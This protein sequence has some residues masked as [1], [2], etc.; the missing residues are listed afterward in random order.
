MQTPP[1]SSNRQENDDAVTAFD[2]VQHIRIGIMS[3]D[4]RLQQLS[5]ALQTRDSSPTRSTAIFKGVSTCLECFQAFEDAVEDLEG[6]S[7]VQ[8]SVSDSPVPETPPPKPV[9]ESPDVS[10][11]DWDR[12]LEEMRRE[13]DPN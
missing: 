7:Y 4:K 5:L 3:M 1:N 11:E 10:D 9:R 2:D 8:S 6:M 12:Y 13:A